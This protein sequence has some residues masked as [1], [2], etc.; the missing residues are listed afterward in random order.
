MPALIKCTYKLLSLQ[1]LDLFL[2]TQFI[3]SMALEIEIMPQL[4]FAEYIID[5]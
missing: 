4:I 3:L 1:G 5:T 2:E